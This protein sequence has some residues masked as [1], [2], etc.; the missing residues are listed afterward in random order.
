MADIRKPQP[1]TCTECHRSTKAYIGDGFDEFWEYRCQENKGTVIGFQDTFDPPLVPPSWC[2]R[3]A[4]TL[5]LMKSK[6]L[7]ARKQA[8][9]KRKS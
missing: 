9:K 6:A 4:A 3:I 8:G 1:F 7:H 2:P 5:K